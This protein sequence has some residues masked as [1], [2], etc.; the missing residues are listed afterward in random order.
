MLREW[1]RH[2]RGAAF[3]FLTFAKYC[4]YLTL[5]ISY[6]TDTSFSLHVRA[7]VDISIQKNEQLLFPRLWKR[8]RHVIWCR[9]NNANAHHIQ[10][11]VGQTQC[12]CW[13]LTSRLFSS[14]QRLGIPT[15]CLSRGWLSWARV[16]CDIKIKRLTE[17]HLD[18]VNIAI[19][20]TVIKLWERENETNYSLL[21]SQLLRCMIS[22]VACE[23]LFFTAP[24]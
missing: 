2:E 5:R 16:E 14:P 21:F 18:Y 6:E 10:A 8:T 7:V 9:L 23:H 19:P 11:L 15:E 22:G 20:A 24:C 13:S 3:V 12:T 4:E 17:C 1:R